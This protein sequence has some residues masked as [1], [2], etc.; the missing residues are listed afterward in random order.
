[1]AA[2]GEGGCAIVNG[3]SPSNHDPLL[4]H[5]RR[6]TRH[7]RPYKPHHAAAGTGFPTMRN[8]PHAR[9]TDVTAII[10]STHAK[11]APRRGRR[12]GGGGGFPAVNMVSPAML[13]CGR[14]WSR[15][16]TGETRPYKGGILC[17]TIPNAITVIYSLAGV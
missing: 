17:P 12:C 13:V 9:E 15:R 11:P 14:W 8:A 2:R 10:T 3:D 6:Q 1:M 7:T 4:P 5:A 16:Q